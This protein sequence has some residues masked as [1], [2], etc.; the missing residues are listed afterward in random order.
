MQQNNKIQTHIF[1]IVFVILMCLSSFLANAQTTDSVRIAI[2]NILAPLNKAIIPT[3]I[4]AE[5]KSPPL[6]LFMQFLKKILTI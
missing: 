3:G 2:N 6:N 5:N 1:K 4:L